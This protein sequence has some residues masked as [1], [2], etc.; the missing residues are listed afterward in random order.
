LTLHECFRS[1]T[2]I[3]DPSESMSSLLNKGFSVTKRHTL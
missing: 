2:S 3:I 1:D